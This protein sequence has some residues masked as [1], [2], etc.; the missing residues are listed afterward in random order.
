MTG[1]PNQRFIS[2]E[3]LFCS[4]N[5]S[6]LEKIGLSK[7]EIKVYLTLLEIGSTTS[8][9]IV[10]ETELR[11]STVYESIRRLQEK[12]LAS[13]VIKDSRRYFEAAQPERIIDF[14]ADKKRKLSDTEKE[15]EHLV[16]ELKKGFDT[17][18]P[19]AE[20]SVFVGVE[21]FKT[22]RR[23]VLNSKTKEHL[24]IGAIGRENEV[25]PGF[26][27]EWNKQRIKRKINLRIL[28]KDSAKDK[29]MTF[30]EKMGPYFE[31]RY[32]PEGVKNPVVINIYKDRVVNIL[33]KGNYPL[34][35]LMKNREVAEAYRNYFEYLWNIAKP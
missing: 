27:E 31:T 35:F 19:Q 17:L 23:D 6:L 22:I 5:T 30:K 10:K 18:K 14:L 2:V 1:R 16:E 26:F 24:L 7:A 29:Y 28:H 9:R 11:K 25:M 15:A 20:A 4:M 21:G 3:Q 13:Y 12:G 8:G 32:L 33:W 34:C